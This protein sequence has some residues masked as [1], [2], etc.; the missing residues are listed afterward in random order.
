[1][2]LLARWFSNQY[3]AISRSATSI[4][5][6]EMILLTR[7]FSN[8]YVAISRTAKLHWCSIDDSTRSLVVEPVCSNLPHRNLHWCSRDDS[9]RSLFLEPVRS[10]LLHR[11]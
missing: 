2:T 3:V 5:V 8:Q 1:M 10:N 7:W 6:R 11:N 9:T 4:G